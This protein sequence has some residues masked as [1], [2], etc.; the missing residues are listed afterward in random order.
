MNYI[1]LN[2]ISTEY[3]IT[4]NN[5]YNITFNNEYIQYTNDIL[6][7][8]NETFDIDNYDITN[9]YITYCIGL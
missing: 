3:N 2:D 8:F 5:E 9:K 4:F 7:I 6:S 1:T